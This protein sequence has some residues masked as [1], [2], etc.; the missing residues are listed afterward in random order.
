MALEDKDSVYVIF[1]QDGLTGEV[2]AIF[3]LVPVGRDHSLC[4]TATLD[5]DALNLG[6]SCYDSFMRRRHQPKPKAYR[7]LL[8][9]I[10]VVYGEDVNVIQ[11]ATDYMHTLRAK[12]ADNDD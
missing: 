5:G 10:K 8:R 11:K 7:E 9:A 1:K 12:R 6:T 3:P 4:V 2:S